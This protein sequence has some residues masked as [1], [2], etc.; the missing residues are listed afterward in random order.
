MGSRSLLPMFLLLLGLGGFIY[1]FEKD[2]PSTDE[3]RAQEKKVLQLEADEVVALTLEWDGQTVRLEKESRDE[4]PG[5]DE[6]EISLEPAVWRQVSPFSARAD[7]AAVSSLVESVV[8]LEHQRKLDEVDRAELGLEEPAATVTLTT[9]EG[10]SVVELGS[11]L[12]ATSHRVVAVR[13]G[14][15]FVVPGGFYADLTRDPGEW[16]EKKL[17]TATRDQI[18][19][20]TLTSG[21]GE[22]TR[23]AL[24]GDRFWIESPVD[25]LADH[26]AIDGLINEVTGLAVSSFVDEPLLDSAGLG[27]EPP[28]GVVEVALKGAESSVRLLLGDETG[29]PGTF[30]GQLGEQ[31]FELETGLVE[32][33]GR[34]AGAWR[35][36]D[37]TT[38]QVFEID[39]VQVRDAEGEAEI[40][41]EE[42][43]WKRGE[44]RID[45]STAS[46]FLYA[47]SDV[48]GE[49]LAELELGGE[50]PVLTLSLVTPDGEEELRLFAPRADGLSPAAASDRDAVLM[51]SAEAVADLEAK[52]QAVRQAEPLVEEPDV[53]D[54]E[55][56]G[57]P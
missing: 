34:A 3:R 54:E 52:W 42:G 38:A 41:R 29:S 5:A 37:W 16:R 12:P 44:D 36:R 11:E 23:L 30:Y 10:D 53:A 17:L 43:E 14:G 50:E 45:Y 46:D 49:S 21:D 57:G 26:E 4:E 7:G 27:L 33:L 28:R 48:R 56:E 40:A 25:D 24:R 6:D 51:L 39:A 35:S 18:E 1:F 47:I 20:V 2:L 32:T 19:R 55:A 15:V 8:G 22:Q 13:G 31:R 9:A